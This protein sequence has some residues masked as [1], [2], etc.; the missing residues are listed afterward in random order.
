[1]YESAPLV[2]VAFGLY[3][4]FTF[5]LAYLARRQAVKQRFSKWGF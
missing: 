1:M 2:P 3:L 4:A 5:L